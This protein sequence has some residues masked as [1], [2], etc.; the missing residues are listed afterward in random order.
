MHAHLRKNK[1]EDLITGNTNQFLDNTIIVEVSTGVV[2]KPMKIQAN[3]FEAST[4]ELLQ[5]SSLTPPQ[6]DQAAHLVQLPS[7]PVGILGLSLSEMKRKCKNHI[8][9][10]IS[11]DQYVEQA[12]SGDMSQLPKQILEIVSKYSAAKKDVS[13]PTQFPVLRIADTSPRCLFSE[14]P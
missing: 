2:F 14:T 13:S 8:E 11:N 3:A 7:A 9:D 12:T 6:A 1:I 4:N 5:H 10:M